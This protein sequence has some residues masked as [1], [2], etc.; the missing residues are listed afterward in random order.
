MGTQVVQP[1]LFCMRLSHSISTS[2]YHHDTSLYSMFHPAASNSADILSVNLFSMHLPW[3]WTLTVI[4]SSLYPSADKTP[5]ATKCSQIHLF[6]MFREW[7]HNLNHKLFSFNLNGSRNIP[8][9]QSL[10]IYQCSILFLF[11]ESIQNTKDSMGINTN[12]WNTSSS[13]YIPSGFRVCFI[14]RQSEWLIEKLYTVHRYTI[15]NGVTVTVYTTKIERIWSALT[16]HS[17]DV[18]V[19]DVVIDNS[20]LT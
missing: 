13:D 5:L 19:E 4:D 12:F 9:T 3:S 17:G 16:G 15:I 6:R 14:E 8:G 2:I 10:W 20:A 18:D 11:Q 1:Q 7:N